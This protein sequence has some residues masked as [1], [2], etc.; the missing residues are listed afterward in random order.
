MVYQSAHFMSKE[1]TNY[2]MASVRNSKT[3]VYVYEDIVLLSFDQT[4]LYLKN[5]L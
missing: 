3:E 4:N 5:K 1:Y 2:L